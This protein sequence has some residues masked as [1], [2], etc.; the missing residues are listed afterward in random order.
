MD[1]SFGF[2]VSIFLERL[3]NSI[4]KGFYAVVLPDGTDHLEGVLIDVGEEPLIINTRNSE[5]ELIL[6]KRNVMAVEDQRFHWGS[7]SLGIL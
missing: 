3:S 6:I 4:D 5:H 7:R 1:R 2:G